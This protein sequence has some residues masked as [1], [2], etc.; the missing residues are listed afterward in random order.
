MAIANQADQ[1][2]GDLLLQRGLINQEQLKKA[3]FDAITSGRPL[4]KVI[5]TSNLVSKEQISKLKAEKF[6]IP[7]IKIDSISIPIETLNKISHDIAEKYL[8]VPFEETATSIK[9]AMADPLDI[10]KVR[11]LTTLLRKNVE[12][13]FSDEDSIRSVIDSRYGA[14][15]GSEVTE[16]LESVGN[17]VDISGTLGQTDILTNVAAAPVVR[18]INMILEYAVKN[19]ASD[20]HIEPREKQIVVRDRINGILSEKLILPLKLG[21]ALVSR[22]KI[23]SNL[24]IDE[25]RVPQDGRFQVKVDHRLIDLRVSIMPSVYGEKVVIRLL[26]KG[27]GTLTLE[28]TGLTGKSYEIFR[29]ALNKTQGIILVTGPTGSGKTVTLASCLK[30]LN[31]PERNIVTIEDPVEIRI[32]GITQVQVNPDVGLTFARG[33]RSFLRQDPDIV[34]VGEIRDKETAELAVQAALTGHLVLSTLH[35]NNAATAVPRLIDMG[36]EPFLLSSTMNI[37]AAQRLARKVCDTC[38]ISYEAS[39]SEIAKL[40]EELSKV[41]GLNFEELLEKSGGKII[42]YKGKGCPEDNYTG[43]K[44][45]I[46]I[47]EVMKMSPEIST[48]IVKHANSQEIQDLAEKQGMVTMVQDGFLKALQGT[49]TISEV[50]RVVS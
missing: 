41:Q 37:T 30:I 6:N 25:H 23:L 7:Y 8:A 26:E 27:A 35:T 46:A 44:G 28:Q 5:E 4:D 19:K 17:V 32:D 40:R 14:Q 9:V 2:I 20:V 36:V 3:R 42:L 16:A 47:F 11:F 22:I 1:T 31:K 21:P 49:T 34:M 33:L 43:Y 18:I 29:E 45:R 13:Y 15:L 38:K 50:M 10:E 12:T 39:E 48:L 24:K